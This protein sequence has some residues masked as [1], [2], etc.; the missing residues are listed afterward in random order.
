MHDL[1]DKSEDAIE[2]LAASESHKMEDTGPVEN[3]V[4]YDIPS[5]HKG[6]GTV[7]CFSMHV[8]KSKSSF[9]HIAIRA[10]RSQ[11]SICSRISSL[12]CRKARMVLNHSKIPY[13]KDWSGY[14]DL[15]PKLK[16]LYVSHR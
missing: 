10:L 6:N 13:T 8:W 7:S 2:E 15:G 12:T 11:C 4:L 14:P 1:F 9:P 16:A 5:I 3:I